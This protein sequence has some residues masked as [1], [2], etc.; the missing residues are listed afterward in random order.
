MP[1]EIV[2]VISQLGFHFK[3][4]NFQDSFDMALFWMV[5]HMGNIGQHLH[6]RK[7]HNKCQMSSLT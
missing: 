6:A 7:G 1:V 5:L 4:L 3:S 2:N